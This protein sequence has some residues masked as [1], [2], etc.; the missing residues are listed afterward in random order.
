MG[1]IFNG[2]FGGSNQK[3][4]SQTNTQSSSENQA[5]PMLSQ[6]LGGQTT[7]ATGASNG[8]AAMLGIGGD[9]A[10]QNAA[11]QNFRNSTG[12]QFGL[13]QGT[14]AITS[15]AAAKGLLNSG[16][17]GK[18]LE[19]Y[20]QNYANQQYQNYLNPLMNL[21]SSG[22]QA[23]QVIAG[24]GQ[25]SNMTSNST[26]SGSGFNGGNGT[27]GGIGSALS[28]IGTLFGK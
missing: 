9:P 21:I 26:S 2:I 25:K 23:G 15:N 16:A 4:S 12:Y 3:N 27:Q 19:S 6:N 5:Y 7:N 24:A 1:D 17:T 18:A 22:N 11:F 10:A 8:L 14:N 20:G 13:D 28:S